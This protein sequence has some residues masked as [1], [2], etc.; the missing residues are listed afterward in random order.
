MDYDDFEKYRD[1]IILSHRKYK[2][3]PSAEPE[4]SEFHKHFKKNSFLNSEYV[5]NEP[6]KLFLYEKFY[7]YGPGD[8][9]AEFKGKKVISYPM[10]G[11]YTKVLP[12]D[13]TIEVEYFNIERTWDIKTSFMYKDNK[14]HLYNKLTKVD[15]TILWFDEIFVYGAW[16]KMP[17]WQELR[18]HYQKTWWFRET[19][20]KKRN[21]II[22]TI[23]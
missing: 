21:R 5:V 8:V 23:I 11:L 12:C 20:R 6:G 2:E 13:Q 9:P 18:P 16:D 7:E 19:K 1:N 17:T 4:L 15:T 22:N 3:I 14:Y 10:M